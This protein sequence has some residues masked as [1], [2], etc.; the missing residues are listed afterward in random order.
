W[1]GVDVPGSG[2]GQHAVYAPVL[3]AIPGSSSVR[4]EPAVLPVGSAWDGL[5]RPVDRPARRY[6]P[7]CLPLG[8]AYRAE[9]EISDADGRFRPD[10]PA[11]APQDK[12]RG[13][14]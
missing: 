2:H 10:G 4:A 13:V 9:P 5:C 1:P 12:L 11:W 14:R 3:Y 7:S 8:P 6:A